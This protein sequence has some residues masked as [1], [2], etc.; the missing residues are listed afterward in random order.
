MDQI[1]IIVIIEKTKTIKD[2]IESHKNFDKRAKDQNKKLKVE[3]LDR[4]ILYIYILIKNKGL[5]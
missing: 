1:K 3:G 4:K 5:N 2:K